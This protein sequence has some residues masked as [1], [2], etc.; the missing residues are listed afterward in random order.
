[1]WLYNP[2]IILDK[3]TLVATQQDIAITVQEIKTPVMYR[4]VRH[5]QKAYIKN[6]DP[7]LL[8]KFFWANFYL[9]SQHLINHHIK[10]GLTEALRDEKKRKRRGK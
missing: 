8:T 9:A 7:Q 1:M 4:A 3:I 5:F 2:V 6:L 10:I